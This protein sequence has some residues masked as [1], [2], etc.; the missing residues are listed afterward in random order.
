MSA[1]W[2]AMTTKDDSFVCV[3]FNMLP[4]ELNGGDVEAERQRIRD[5][6]ISKSNRDIVTEDDG[7]PHAEQTMTLLRQLGSDLNINAFALNWRYADGTLNDD[8][9]E[10]N[11]LMQRVIERV[12]LDSP[13][14]MPTEIPFYL[15]S[16]E[17]THELYG[18]CA[19]NFKKRLQ[20]KEN[21]DAP[22]DL[23]V[24]RNVVMSP[25]P[26]QNTFLGK[27]MEGFKEVVEEEVEVIPSLMIC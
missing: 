13:D 3:P 4:S 23:F 21:M 1:Y 22:H 27:M 14:D 19:A 16:T 26:S 17:F 25:F 11:Y 2:A 8:V 20:L 10:A 12:S 6:I 18:S 15:T 7:K 9:E 5:E 24:L